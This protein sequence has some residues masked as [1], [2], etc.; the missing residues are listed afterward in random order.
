MEFQDGDDLSP[1]YILYTVL[2]VDREATQKDIK[3]KYYE[4][5]RGLHPDKNPDDPNATKNFQKLNEAYQI[6]S[7][8]DKRKI[9]D[10]TGDLQDPNFDINGFVSAYQYYREMY[11]EISKDDIDDF[12]KAYPDSKDEQE[13]LLDFYEDYGGDVSGLLECIP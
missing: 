2:Q 12:A 5:A 4:L 6:L 11:K 8:I 9:Y 13:D 7:D 10:R 3:K 1:K